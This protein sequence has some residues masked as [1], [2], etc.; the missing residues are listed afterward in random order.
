MNKRR[1][2]GGGGGS[3]GGGGMVK[4]SGAPRQHLEQQGYRKGTRGESEHQPP[5][6]ALWL[7]LA[8]IS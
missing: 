8:I 6:T 7:F 3:G 5:G 1:G 2:G 4:V